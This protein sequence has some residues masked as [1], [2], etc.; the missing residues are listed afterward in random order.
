RNSAAY[1]SEIIRETILELDRIVE[2]DIKDLEAECQRNKT[3]SFAN[4]HAH[5]QRSR[6]MECRRHFR[7]PPRPPTSSSSVLASRTAEEHRTFEQRTQMERTIT[8]R[9]RSAPR[10]NVMTGDT[11]STLRKIDL[12]KS[13]PITTLYKVPPPPYSRSSSSS[14]LSTETTLRVSSPEPD[15][16]PNQPLKPLYITEIIV[17]PKPVVRVQEA[18]RTTVVTITD[19]SEIER[20]NREI[21]R[22]DLERKTLL[23]EKEVLLREIDRYKHQP[24]PKLPEKKTTSITIQ[25]NHEHIHKTIKATREVAMQHVVEDDQPPPLPPKQR[26]QRDVAINH[27]TEYD[28]DEEKQNEIVRKKLEDIKNFYTERIHFLEGKI[29]EQERDIERLSEPKQLRH[30]NTQCQPTMQ[31]RALATDAV[32]SVRDVALTCQLQPTLPDPVAHRDVS[33]QCNKDDLIQT[34]DVWMEALP[35]IPVKRDVSIGVSLNVIPD[36]HFRDVGTHVNFDYKPEIRQRDVATMFAPEPIERI[37][38]SSNTQLIQTRDFG[39][40]ADT[41]EPPKPPPKPVTRPMATD[42]FNLIAHKD[43]ACGLNEAILQQDISTD[44]NALVS[45]HDRAS[46]LDIPPELLSRH[47]S[48]DT[49]TLISFRDNFSATTPLVQTVHIDAQTQSIHAV[50]H[51]ASSNT[52]AL[53]EQCH[54]GIQAVQEP[55]VVKHSTTFTETEIFHQL[56]HLRHNLTNTDMK[57]S[58]DRAISTERRQSRDLAINTEPKIMYSKDVGDYDVRVGEVRNEEFT[59]NS[60]YGRVATFERGFQTELVDTNRR[61]G[62]LS[63]EDDVEEQRQEVITF[64]LPLE[65]QTTEEIYETTITTETMESNRQIEEIYETNVTTDKTLDRVQQQQRAHSPEELIEESY[66]IVSTLTKPRNGDVIITTNSPRSTLV[67]SRTTAAAAVAA[68]KASMSED[69]NSYCEEWTVTEAKRKEGGETVQTTIDR[70]GHH[71]YILTGEK[72]IASPNYQ[73]QR[74]GHSIDSQ[75]IHQE[76]TTT[77]FSPSV[78]CTSTLYETRRRVGS[79]H[80]DTHG[81]SSRDPL[82]N[83]PLVEEKYEVTVSSKYDESGLKAISSQP[84]IAPTNASE[85]FELNEEIYIACVVV[86]ESLYDSHVDRKKANNCLQLIQHEWFHLCSV[87]EVNLLLIEAFLNSIK[88]NFSNFL[89]EKIVNLQDG[90]GNTA[91]HYSVTNNHWQVVRMLLD[92]KVCDVCQQ[93]NAGYTAVMMAAVI[94]I[95]NDDQ[96]QIVRRLF[97]ESGNVNVKAKDNQQTALMLAVK[98]GKADLVELLIRNGAGVNLQDADGSTALMYAVEHGSLN[99]VKLLLA[100]PECNVNITD[101]SGQTAMTIA[102]NKNRKNILVELY[103]RVKEQKGNQPAVGSNSHNSNK[104]SVADRSTPNNSI[105]AAATGATIHSFRRTSTSEKGPIISAFRRYSSTK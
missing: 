97:R 100:Q 56:G 25:T 33:L 65:T 50:Q 94:D 86:N 96:R 53:A 26:Q 21:E 98:H 41:I 35:E 42:T 11:I 58:T 15:R 48:T 102:T 95:T 78:V 47:V 87:K 18:I 6:S 66:E 34:R 30:V 29:Q 79:G 81:R 75:A 91:L 90:N 63:Q 62:Y 69:E 76:E 22:L 59:W 85:R 55:P 64:C 13:G 31:D 92:T 17:P 70:G 99:I 3:Q 43:V 57:R 39:A 52:P 44:T 104:H 38:R 19:K 28:E 51:D 12:S 7:P 4:N 101:K 23:N 89:L 1:D 54:T 88:N 36:R 27:R 67:E 60:L 49:R 2:K 103:A 8:T 80:S 82:L 40:F 32:R 68:T 93:N 45:L 74:S 77:R 73:Q 16:Q 61:V 10:L 83:E 72:L 14:S 105:Q 24:I 84:L 5:Q 9:T 20:R 37:D 71:R 46:G